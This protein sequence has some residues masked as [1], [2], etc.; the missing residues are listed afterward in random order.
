MS[1]PV[2]ENMRSELDEYFEGLKAIRLQ[3][4]Y[5]QMVRKRMGIL[6]DVVWKY[7]LTRPGLEIIPTFADVC[8][9]EPFHALI[10]DSPPETEITKES[11]D[12]LMVQLPEL[13]AEWNRS[14]VAMLLQLVPASASLSDPDPADQVVSPLDLATTFFRCSWCTDPITY[15]RVL[16]HSCLMSFH[17]SVGEDLDDHVLAACHSIGRGTLP[18]NYGREQVTYDEEAAEAAKAI[19]VACGQDLETIS[20]SAMDQLDPRVECLRCV[21]PQRGRMVMRWRTAVRMFVALHLDS[22]E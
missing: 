16:K 10:L 7:T 3:D 22:F 18:W 8:I 5:L 21:H 12:N 15:P 13:S 4:E 20:A 1:F 17:S 2:W 6:V 9:M 19:V 14:N 11:I